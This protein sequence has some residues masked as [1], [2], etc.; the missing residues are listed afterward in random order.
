MIQKTTNPDIFVNPLVAYRTFY[1][2]KILLNIQMVCPLRLGALKI[3]AFDRNECGDQLQTIL[4]LIESKEINLLNNLTSEIIQKLNNGQVLINQASLDISAPSLC[5]EKAAG[6]ICNVA[7]SA[8]THTINTNVIIQDSEATPEIVAKACGFSSQNWKIGT[9]SIL[10]IAEPDGFLWLPYTITKEQEAEIKKL[11]KRGLESILSSNNCN[12]FIELALRRKIIV[13]K[14][15]SSDA[16]F[17]DCQSQFQQ[18]GSCYVKNIIPASKQRDIADYFWQLCQEGLLRK[19]D[20]VCK[21]R[22]WSHNE[23]LSRLIQ[24]QLAGLVSKITQ[25]EYKPAF[26]YFVSYR[27]EAK[28][29]KHKDREEASISMSILVDYGCLEDNIFRPLKDQWPLYVEDK[30]Q[31]GTFKNFTIGVGSAALFNGTMLYHYRDPI[32]KHHISQNML[33]HFVPKEYEGP[34]R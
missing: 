3:T 7:L 10:W 34:L 30:S 5:F 23:R 1:K 9:D 18:S 4:R 17:S 14:D 29:K 33:L 24:F 11:L 6:S 31:K 20:S 16:H 19:G 22:L 8:R 26:T 21:E 15:S 12:N 25:R 13:S 28:L 27:D 32:P 2:A